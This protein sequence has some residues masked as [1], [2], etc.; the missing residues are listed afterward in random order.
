[1]PQWGG[2]S[3]YFLRFAD[4]N[5]NEEFASMEK[6][7]Y[8]LPVDWYSGGM[9]HVTRHLIYSRFWNE[10]LFD[11]GEVPV[12]EPYKKRGLHGLILGTDGQKMSKSKG[13]VVDPL[14][15]VNQYGA[16]VLRLFIL[17]I[18]DFEM[19]TPWNNDSIKG[20]ARFLDKV[21]A[22]NENVRR[23]DL[24][25][26]KKLKVII[27]KTIKGVSED[28]ENSKFNT[29]VAKLMILVNAYTEEE[30][31]SQKDYE[32]L[33]KLLNP[34]C[35]HMAEEL[36]HN[37]HDDTI[38]YE[39]YP[40]YSEKDLV[41]DTCLMVVSVNGKVRDKIEVERGLSDDKVTE[42]VLSRDRIK[43]YIE[44]GYKKIIIIKDKI[45]NIVA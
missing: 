24:E 42:I 36:W 30:T 13:N 28:I 10:F 12:K 22:L 15:I 44:N 16:D 34:Y 6:M 7:K 4:S 27:N 9:E 23:G 8:W 19:A 5:N 3:W 20:C 1:M 26:S 29:A 33:L 25:Y 11:Q 45:V 18:S 31:I 2:S 43:P 21:E 14:E 38:Q 17:F 37:Y 39:S 41:E 35:P 40:T 32:T